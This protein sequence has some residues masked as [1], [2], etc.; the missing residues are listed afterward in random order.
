MGEISDTQ[1]E[2]DDDELKAKVCALHF[3]N[4]SQTLP[5][6]LSSSRFPFHSQVEAALHQFD[7][8]A[9]GVINFIE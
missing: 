5:P 4:P 1:L 2:V 8:D 9:D 7:E 6:K 3:E